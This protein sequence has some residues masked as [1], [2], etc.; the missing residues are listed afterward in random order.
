TEDMK[1]EDLAENAVTILSSIES[2]L[3][4]RSA[5]IGKVIVKTTMGMPIEVPIGR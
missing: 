4:A 1:A 2:K 5:N 3:P